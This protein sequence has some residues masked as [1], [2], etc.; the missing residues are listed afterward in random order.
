MFVPSQPGMVSPARETVDV[1]VSITPAEAT[2]IL[3]MDSPVFDAA[4][5]AFFTAFSTWSA[6]VAP[7]GWLGTRPW[8]RTACG[9]L[10]SMSP[11]AILVPPMSIA[12][13][14]ATALCPFVCCREYFFSQCV[15]V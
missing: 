9:E 8:V 11:Q 2:P 1:S 12:S 13:V 7:G 3:S 6:V 14:M 15:S 5:S 10:S 4:V